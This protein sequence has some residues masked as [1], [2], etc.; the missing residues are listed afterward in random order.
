MSPRSPWRL[1]AFVMDLRRRSAA[2]ERPT[3]TS[4]L[5]WPRF[6]TPHVSSVAFARFHQ[7]AGRCFRLVAIPIIRGRENERP[8]LNAFGLL[9]TVARS[10]ARA[11]RARRIQRGKHRD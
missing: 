4:F 11:R 9:T 1:A 10:F 2:S 6:L 5:N 8:Y 7:G 3:F